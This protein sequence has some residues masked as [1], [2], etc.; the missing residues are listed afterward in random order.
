MLQLCLFHLLRI[1]LTLLFSFFICRFHIL[2][3]VLLCVNCEKYYSALTYEEAHIYFFKRTHNFRHNF[4]VL[5]LHPVFNFE[6][7]CPAPCLLDS[8]K[9]WISSLLYIFLIC[10]SFVCPSCCLPFGCCLRLQLQTSPQPFAFVKKGAIWTFF[11]RH[12]V[13]K[14]RAVYFFGGGEHF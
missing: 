3:A 12:D 6:F 8:L 9:L 2:L 11:Y 7:L 5:V 1:S 4:L 10:F 13:P 14:G